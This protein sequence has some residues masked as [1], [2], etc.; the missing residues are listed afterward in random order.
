MSRRVNTFGALLG[1]VVNFGPGVAVAQKKPVT[2]PLVTAAVAGQGVAVLPLG[3]VV[4]DQEMAIGHLRADRATLLH[5]SDSLILANL[6]TKAPEVNW[7]SPAELRRASRRSAGLAP[8]PDQMG[9]AIMRSWSL[10]IVPDPLRSGLRRLL[11]IA[12]GGRLALIPASLQ[13]RPD[14]AGALTADMSLVLADVRTGRVLW[15]SVARGSGG[16]PEEVFEKAMTTVFPGD[17]NL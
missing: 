13:F 4:V 3:M 15:R 11:A 8:E 12:G 9:Q 10:T 14:S 5:W 16:T 7:I 1:L 6:Q 17:G 2:Q